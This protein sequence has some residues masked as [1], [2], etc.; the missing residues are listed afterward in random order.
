MH[1]FRFYVCIV[2]ISFQIKSGPLSI[3]ATVDVLKEWY[4]Q[5]RSS[6]AQLREINEQLSDL[7]TEIKGLFVIIIIKN[8]AF[9]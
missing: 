6:S 7:A 1:W 5:D 4:A 2:Y 8:Q 9:L 3:D